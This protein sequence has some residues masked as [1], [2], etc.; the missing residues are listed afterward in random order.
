MPK[1]P[2]RYLQIEPWV[3]REEGFH[4]ERSR[5]SESVFSLANEY[6]GVRGYFEEGFGGA[7][8]RGSF[9]NGVYETRH[10][11]HPQ[12]FR[13]LPQTLYYMAN[14]VDWLFTRVDAA[15]EVLDLATCRYDQFARELDLRSGVLWR[16][17][18]WQTRDGSADYRLRF[19][20]LVSMERPHIGAQRIEVECIRGKGTIRIQAGVDCGLVHTMEDRCLWRTAA[21][22]EDAPSWIYAQTLT[23]G[24]GAFACYRL[25]LDGTPVTGT[26]VRD[27]ATLSTE[28]TI[29][30]EEGERRT[31]ERTAYVESRRENGTSVSGFTRSA[32]QRARRDVLAGWDAL[33]AEQRGHWERTWETLDVQI[34]GDLETQQGARFCLY[35]LH[36]SYAGRDPAFNVAAKGLTGESYFGWVWWDTETYCLPFYLFTNP[37]ASKNLLMFRYKTLPQARERAKEMDCRGACYP[38]GT[39]DGTES[40][41]V[42]QH[43]NLEVHVTAA[44][45]YG[46]RHYL[47]VTGDKE[48]LYRY[49]FEI[50]AECA[51]YFASRGEWS[52]RGD[53]GIYGVMG[54]DEF[55]MMVHN[56]AYTNAM[57]RH[58]FDFAL[59]A[60]DEMSREAPRDLDRVSNAIGLEH[61]E[62]DEWRKKSA[63]IR[64][65]FDSDTRLFEQHDGYFDLPHV[66]YRTL[67]PESFPLYENWAYD[68]IFRYDMIKQP[69]VLLLML[70]F[71]SEFDDETKR[72][73]YEFY[74]PRCSHESSLSPG[75]H[76]ILA[77]ELGR[78][79]EAEDLFGFATRLDLDDYNRN[80]W[81]GLHVTSMAAAWMNIVYGFGGMRSDGESLSFRPAIPK[82]WKRLAFSVR[83]RGRLI[84]VEISHAGTR[85]SLRSGDPLTIS[86]DGKP[87]VVGGKA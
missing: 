9:L 74:E 49:G 82:H 35:H 26:A 12:N 71:S 6:M 13:G 50:V 53:F 76:S 77:N 43:G 28:I 23:T 81:Q 64:T 7:S 30:L 17:F 21:A 32:E 48:F 40:C 80:T 52:P 83:Y 59:S 37:E 73:N 85:F 87:L 44:I 2:T 20:R 84:A 57:A 86:L 54:A 66:D 60:F 25:S 10:V 4:P 78:H 22:S 42:W 72:V 14:A 36:Q 34:D 33:A 16:S 31:I 38:M 5:E 8:D 19:G 29:N 63:A 58:V 69:D 75:I 3:I 67:A 65:N 61:G 56:S 79:Q 45:P 24:F 55:H 27:G 39:I 41:H 70:F 11:D 68:R 15:D 46:I 18:V 62:L 51:R 1:E 47:Q